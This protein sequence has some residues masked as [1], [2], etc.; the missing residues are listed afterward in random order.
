MRFTFLLDILVGTHDRH[1][2]FLDE[3]LFGGFVYGVVAAHCLGDIPGHVL[4][5]CFARLLPSRQSTDPVGHHEQRRA[6]GPGELTQV[7]VG[8]AGLL[9]LDEL[10]E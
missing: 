6:T 9:D 5:R 7:S 4:E 1:A 3:P 8:Q 10:H 2:Q